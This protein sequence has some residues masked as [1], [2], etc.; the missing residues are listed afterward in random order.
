MKI[1]ELKTKSG[2]GLGIMLKELR[3]KQRK[4]KFDLTEKKLKNFGEVSETRKTIARIITLFKQ[5]H[6]E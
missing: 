2:Q 6:G 3:E 4:L 5:K 1:E